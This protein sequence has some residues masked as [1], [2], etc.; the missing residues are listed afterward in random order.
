MKKLMIIIVL[1]SFI[2]V[3]TLYSQDVVNKNDILKSIVKNYIEVLQVN[4]LSS[5]V[6]KVDYRSV[7]E[8]EYF[9]LKGIDLRR[10][11]AYEP[12]YIFKYEDYVVLVY[13]GFEK[14]L[15]D[16][17]SNRRDTS[18]FDNVL[19]TLAQ[20]PVVNDDNLYGKMAQGII[21]DDFFTYRYTVKD[22]VVSKVE[23]IIPVSVKGLY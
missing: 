15:I 22:G 14:Y 17:G 23:R 5:R 9:L 19:S 7:D 20:D 18:Q 8:M 1:T 6:I 12:S 4:E 3:N 13:S 16:L 2:K 10:E 21:K 11:L